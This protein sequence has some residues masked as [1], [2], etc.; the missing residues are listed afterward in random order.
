MKFCCLAVLAALSFSLACG[1]P[2]MA[3]PPAG[4]SA[5]YVFHDDEDHTI[6]SPDGAVFAKDNAEALEPG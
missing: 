4:P 5:D 1:V 3:A 6:K 2:A